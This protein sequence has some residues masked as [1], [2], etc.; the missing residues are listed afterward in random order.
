MYGAAEETEARW[1]PV[2]LTPVHVL[3]HWRP[4]D[5]DLPDP[6]LAQLV[7]EYVDARGRMAL[8]RACVP[9]ARLVVAHAPARRIRSSLD[10]L[11]V[12]P[13]AAAAGKK[14]KKRT[15]LSAASSASTSTP[16]SSSSLASPFKQLL[17]RTS[18]SVARSSGA[19]SPSSARTSRRQPQ[20]PV[21]AP[22]PDGVAAKGWRGL[23]CG[24]APGAA[25]PNGEEAG[26]A[27]PAGVL[28]P[29]LTSTSS[30]TSEGSGGAQGRGGKGREQRDEGVH[31]SP[32]LAGE[33][34]LVRSCRRGA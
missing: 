3:V 22:G 23:L 2:R 33:E 24:L 14:K 16:T 1:Q 12:S 28:S 27:S 10:A 11:C 19:A 9:L 8:F 6:F 15:S 20:Q 25:A 26:A 18:S 17:I 29:A 4:D 31:L 7:R 21:G 5:A 30:L 32:N 34:G 13:S